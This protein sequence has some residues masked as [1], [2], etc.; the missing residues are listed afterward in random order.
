MDSEELLCEQLRRYLEL[1]S[2]EVQ[3]SERTEKQYIRLRDMI[4]VEI[5]FLEHL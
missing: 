5:Y 1:S 2:T 4:I 3:D